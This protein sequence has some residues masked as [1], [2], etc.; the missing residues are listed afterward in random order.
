MQLTPSDPA[1]PSGSCR[2]R[3][4]GVENELGGIGSP[5]GITKVYEEY[6]VHD[7]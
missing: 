7:R 3:N 2:R 6:P 1:R 4:L 5:L